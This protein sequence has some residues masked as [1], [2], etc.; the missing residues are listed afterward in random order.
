MND[1]HVVAL[2]YLVHHHDRVDYSKAGPLAFETPGFFVEVKDQKARFE[3]KQHHGTEEDARRVVEPFIRN[4][5]FESSLSHDP[6]CF[7]LEFDRA[8]IVD[9][10]PTPGVVRGRGTHARV[11]ISISPVSRAERNQTKGR[12]KTLPP[13][14]WG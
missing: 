5:E 14:R 13:Q 6:E 11:K 8:E 9:R 3:L 4:W 2:H 7:R 10:R 1:P 12:S